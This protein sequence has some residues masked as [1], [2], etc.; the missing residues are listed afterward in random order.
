[1]L[2]ILRDINL[3]SKECFEMGLLGNGSPKSFISVT[4]PVAVTEAWGGPQH[5]N[6]VF[7]FESNLT[8]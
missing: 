5:C 1:M 6:L 4:C 7:M 3:H 8:S 2:N